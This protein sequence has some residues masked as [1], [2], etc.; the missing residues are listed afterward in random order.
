MH[1]PLRSHLKI[2][3]K[4]LRYLKG[5]PG[6]G[7]HIV[8]QPKTSLEAF[9]DADWA[10]CL[11]TKKSVTGFCV[12]LNGSLVSWKSKKQNTLSKSSAEAKYRAMAF[13]TFEVTWILK[14]L[15]DL[16][17]DQVLPVNL[18]CET[19]AA[20]KIVANHVFYERT[21]HLEIELHFVREIFYQGLLKLQKINYVVQP[22]II[23]TKGLDKSQHENL[24]LKL[25]MV[26]MFQVQ[27]NGGC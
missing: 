4:V 24:V 6:R 1:K 2:A 14:V 18:F 21:K 12:K 7:V 17:W 20:I 13:I 9:V 22:A 19:Q 11:V 26:D 15:K 10:K 3:L 8:K 5:N 27:V 23:F 16:N 25:G